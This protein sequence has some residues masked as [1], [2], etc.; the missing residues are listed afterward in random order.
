MST[1]EQKERRAQFLRQMAT[2][3][4]YAWLGIDRTASPEEISAA[5]ERMREKLKTT[6]MPQ[7]KRANER[8]FCDQGEKVLLRPDIRRQYD[9]L[10]GGAKRR[11]PVEVG[12]VASRK[13]AQLREERLAEARARVQHYDRDDV[14]MSPG[15]PLP[16]GTPAVQD[17]LDEE[18][19]A[20][21]RHTDAATALRA[22]RA[23]RVEADPLRAIALAERAHALG[24]SAGTLRTL[25]AAHRDLADLVESTN[26][27]RESVRI[28]PGLR[29]NAPGWAALSAT[30]TAAGEVDEAEAIALRLVRDDEEDAYGW[31]VLALSSAARGD[32]ARS[33]EAWERTARLGLDVPGALQGL[34]DLRRDCLARGDRTTAVDLEGRL[35][36]L[37]P[38]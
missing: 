16:L 17:R 7:A 11:A 20:T 14:I 35:A 10:L 25:G 3:D 4:L 21:A 22:A 29:E 30:L 31:R 18:R 24:A 15:V 19:D 32:V 33:A 28:L 1:E 2:R 26:L 36:R 38:R 5:A 9:A 23:A 27:L 37:R 12:D 6:P 13:A 34:Q 8:A